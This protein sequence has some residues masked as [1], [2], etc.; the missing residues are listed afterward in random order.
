MSERA[1][2]IEVRMMYWTT[3]HMDNGWSVLMMRGMLVFWTA[4]VVA[5]VWAPYSSSQ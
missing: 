1:D 3:D 2:T 4:L 5:I